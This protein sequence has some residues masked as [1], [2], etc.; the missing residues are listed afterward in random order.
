MFGQ[1]LVYGLAAMSLAFI[2]GEVGLVCFGQAL[3]FGAGAYAMALTAKGMIPG[4][5][6]SAWLGLFLGIVAGAVVGAV[7]G[8]LLFFGIGLKSAY[9]GIVTLAAAVIAERIA[10][11]WRYI[12]GFNG[13]LDVPP[14]PLPG[15][16]DSADPMMGYLLVLALAIVCW[17]FLFALQRS[18][19]GTVLRGIRCDERRMLTLGFSVP[20]YKM[21]ALAISGAVAGLAGALFALQFSFV[22]PAVIGLAL[23]TEILIWAAVGGKAVLIA[24]FIGALGVK[25]VEGTLSESIGAYWLLVIGLAFVAVIVI[26]PQGLLGKLLDIGLPKRLRRP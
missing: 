7:T 13:L 18:P 14:L 2:W 6:D 8:A 21:V 20:I 26:F 15:G 22:S 23:S 4:L 12:G 11:N 25:W 9:F 19:F 24:A 10:T 17:L 3:F 5:P 1:L 16:T